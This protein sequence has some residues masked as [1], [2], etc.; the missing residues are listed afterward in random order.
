MQPSTRRSTLQVWQEATSATAE[1][2]LKPPAR[3]AESVDALVSNTSGA[4]RAGSIPAPGTR[5]WPTDTCRP[6]LYKIFPTF[7]PHLTIILHRGIKILRKIQ[8]STTNV[9]FVGSTPFISSLDH[10]SGNMGVLCTMPSSVRESPPKPKRTACRRPPAPVMKYGLFE[11][12]VSA[13][14]PNGG[15]IFGS[16]ARRNISSAFCLSPSLAY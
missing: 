12:G 11:V 6:F 3:M 5:K 1:P 9:R 13:K 16:Y 2:P 4:I 14:T 7:S 15:R 10:P 8:F